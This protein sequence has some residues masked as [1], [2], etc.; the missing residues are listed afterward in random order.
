VK[1]F[2]PVSYYSSMS[3][4]QLARILK[5]PAVQKDH[6]E[7]ITAIL[8]ARAAETERSLR[9]MRE[10]EKSLKENAK[11]SGRMFPGTTRLTTKKGRLRQGG[12][13]NPR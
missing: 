4:I 6:R 1:N 10:Y 2:D 8:N 3:D 12:R 11:N 9:F 13:V 7:T 5:N